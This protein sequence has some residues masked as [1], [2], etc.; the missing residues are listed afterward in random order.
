MR[1]LIASAAMV[2]VMAGS[3][4]FGQLV[5]KQ[6]NHVYNPAF[7]VSAYALSPAQE[8][9]YSS[10]DDSMSV[11]WKAWDM[12]PSPNMQ[13]G[14]LKWNDNYT[15][16]DAAT[17]LDDVG[18]N[19]R[20]AY[21]V[22]GVYI[23]FEVNDN[24]YVGYQNPN[25]YENDGVEFLAAKY[26]AEALYGQNTQLRCLDD[27]IYPN[28]ALFEF[29]QIQIRYGLKLLEPVTTFSLNYWDPSQ[30]G[31]SN[32]NLGP[33]GV[34]LY[35]R[36][37]SML[38]NAEKIQ[39]EILEPND[40][41]HRQ[42]WLIPWAS[43]GGPN[44]TIMTQRNQGEKL[45][46]LF[47]YNDLDVGQ[48]QPTGLRWRRADPWSEPDV[49]NNKSFD[50]WGDLAFDATLLSKIQAVN[51]ACADNLDCLQSVRVG[52]PI[53]MRPADRIAKT[54]YFSVNGQRL[55]MVNGKLK[56]AAGTMVLQKITQANGKTM[57]LRTPVA[58]R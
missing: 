39:A 21:G 24:N 14:E 43:W 34:M 48:T 36:Q 30:L 1:R 57:T 13:R 26:S 9:M 31:T 40:T 47:G 5:E 18:F 10:T 44:P 58:A 56:A 50:C 23:L 42:E 33:G 19:A 51:S 49:A 12:Q 32:C 38:D 37:T 54:E 16:G 41:W 29:F 35:N 3:V 45:A 28:Q 2:T 17:G 55:N 22:Q 6:S 27:A 46:I 11:F 53:A 4:A 52:N 20:F 15:W 25:D 7:T 8:A